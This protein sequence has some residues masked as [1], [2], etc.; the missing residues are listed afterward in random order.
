[1]RH[2]IFRAQLLVS[3]VVVVIDVVYVSK[4]GGGRD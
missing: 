2:S 3:V 4:E 1:M